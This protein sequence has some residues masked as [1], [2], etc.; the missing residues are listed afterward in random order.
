MAVGAIGG[1][2]RMMKSGARAVPLQ[3]VCM[4]TLPLEPRGRAGDRLVDDQIARSHIVSV[5]WMVAV[6]PA[7]MVTMV[8]LL[9]SRSATLAL[10]PSVLTWAV[11]SDPAGMSS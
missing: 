6:P 9:S 5:R 8:P 10:L 3:T 4:T 7:G 2:A 11:H 1:S